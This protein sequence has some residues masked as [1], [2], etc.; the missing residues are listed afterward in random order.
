MQMN[1]TAA[2]TS[3]WKINLTQDI[4]FLVLQLTQAQ[5]VF[6]SQ[7]IS[8]HAHATLLACFSFGLLLRRGDQLDQLK[9]SLTWLRDQ[10]QPV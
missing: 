8:Q 10:F 6:Q 3:S 4:S 5:A 2:I 7:L 9:T 1:T